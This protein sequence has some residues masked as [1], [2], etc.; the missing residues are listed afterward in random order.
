MG[1]RTN[2]K[3]QKYKYWTA[4]G[5]NTLE[6]K[7]YT[8]PKMKTVRQKYKYSEGRMT[9][10]REF[11]ELEDFIEWGRIWD[12]PFL[13]LY[14]RNEQHNTVITYISVSSRACIR[15]GGN[16]ITW[17]ITD[18]RT[19]CNV[20]EC[21]TLEMC[22]AVIFLIYSVLKSSPQIETASWIKGMILLHA[23]YRRNRVL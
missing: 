2:K 14:I 15:I 9:W 1:R 3:D 20:V 7:I 21:I 6:R 17:P 16:T 8:N 18:R 4:E 10:K 23:M 13:H 19:G 12:Y 11:E 22:A 5:E